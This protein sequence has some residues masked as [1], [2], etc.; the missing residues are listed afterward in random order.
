MAPSGRLLERLE[1]AL[2]ERHGCIA[3][4]EF[5]TFLG[6]AGAV[7]AENCGGRALSSDAAFYDFLLKT[8]LE[9]S[10]G[11]G[12]PGARGCVSAVRAAVRDVTDACI[13]P[14]LVLEHL[15]GDEFRKRSEAERVTWLLGIQ[16]A[17]LAR[18]EKTSQLPPYTLFRMAAELAPAS[19]YLRG[20]DSIIFYGFYD[21]TG[22]QY[23]L[24]RAVVKAG[25]SRFLYYPLVKHPAYEFARRF[26][27][28]NI[29]GLSSETLW[30][31]EDWK[32]CAVGAALDGLFTPGAAGAHVSGEKLSVATVSG[33]GDELWFAAKEILR[34]VEREGYA[35]SDICVTARTFEPYLSRLRQMFAEQGV[36]VADRQ[37]L[38]LLSHPLA[39][40]AF[41]I[42]TARES[43]FQAK[44][45]REIV[46]SPYFKRSGEASRWL[47]VSAGLGAVAGPGNICAALRHAGP[48]PAEEEQGAL[49]L[50]AWA[51]ELASRLEAL[52]QAGDW[53]LLCSQAMEVLERQL[54]PRAETADEADAWRSFRECVL[55]L[56]ALADLRPALKG[57]F[58]EE[59][60][61]RVE[62]SSLKYGRRAPG[63]VRVLDAMAARGHSFRAVIALGLNEKLFPRVVREDPIL[64]D[65]H[66]R[67]LRDAGGFWITPKLEGYEEERLLFHMM[68]SSAEERLVCVCC[69]SD[70]EGKAAVPSLYLEE[71]CASCGFLL[72]D[73]GRVSSVPRRFADK[74]SD[75]DSRL[76]SAGE[77]SAALSLFG[78]QA[79]YKNAALESE[80]FASCR[81]KAADLRSARAPGHYDG[82]AGALRGF[83][84]GMNRRG[85]SPSA[86]ES[87]L[88][89]PMQ[90]FLHYALGLDSGGSALDPGGLASDIKGRLYH[91]ALRGLY[92]H[93]AGK[94]CS[95]GEA[96]RF[97]GRYFNSALSGSYGLYPLVWKSLS[98]D[99]TR[100]LLR[101]FEADCAIGGGFSPGE[102]E[103]EG[104]AQSR[105]GFN[106]HG[107]MDR[108]DINEQEKAVR[109]VDYKTS[110][111]N[112]PSKT[113][114]L[115]SSGKIFQPFI[116][117]ELAGALF[118]SKGFRAREAVFLGIEDD[119]GADGQPASQSFTRAD[120][121]VSA[122][123]VEKLSAVLAELARGGEFF[124]RPALGERE[125]C[126]WCAYDGICRNHHA[127]SAARA[128]ESAPARRLESALDG[129]GNEAD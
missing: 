94:P 4:V 16:R 1:R 11:D 109:V 24:L 97:L 56:R 15:Q 76:L 72:R 67:F 112:R 128:D 92:G 123:L 129:G 83:W 119:F 79:A 23:E 59:L 48:D 45:L 12:L 80:F 63:G 13:D 71:L 6:L 38:P 47:A 31:D 43:G 49:S 9:K 85:L 50:A 17:Y 87:L 35:W 2:L 26:Y 39:R 8:V 19:Q 52:S 77:L 102:F 98:E 81:G 27:E 96:A 122:P 84:D 57:E 3:G 64:R 21:L 58:L 73:A 101:L 116:Y 99:M 30:L 62:A 44:R 46:S 61:A 104:F 108:L 113:E 18:L 68:V 93:M 10:G 69:R 121:E 106:V 70:E 118:E 75:C 29:A 54:D 36:P 120:Y 33:R 28:S 20:F 25:G 111:K 60:A 34:L 114:K 51:E 100:R 105:C 110:I 66:R 127:A 124:I 53:N 103:R 90:F 115:L 41:A 117:L 88:S 65:E 7:A 55:G 42:L 86:L 82:M 74:F 37:P 5:R 95:P 126:S 22:L 40:T 14:A 91:E 78:S 32:D 125:R 107:R 89:C